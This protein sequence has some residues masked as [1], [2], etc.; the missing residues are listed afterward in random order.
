RRCRGLRDVRGDQRVHEH[1]EAGEL[2]ADRAQLD[3]A[4]R[5]D[6]ARLAAARP[7]RLVGTS[8]R[9]RGHRPRDRRLLLW[10]RH[11]FDRRGAR[12]FR[13]VRAT[14]EESVPNLRFMSIGNEPNSS[15]FWRGGTKAAANGY[16]ELLAQAYDVLKV[17]N[18]RISVIGCSL[19]SRH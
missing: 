9:G 8:G 3:L 7:A 16:Y 11:R 6:R 4:A 14:I 13:A 12:R 5:E 19:A 10:P 18:P 2:P 17:N 1:G 15:V